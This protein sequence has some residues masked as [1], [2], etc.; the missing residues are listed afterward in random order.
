MNKYTSFFTASLACVSASCVIEAQS[1]P[2][3]YTGTL[4]LDWTIS[5]AKD[6]NACTQC[7]VRSIAIDLRDGRGNVTENDGADCGAFATTIRVSEGCYKVR[8]WLIEA[9]ATPPTSAITLPSLD[10]I[11]NTRASGARRL[12]RE[13]LFLGRLLYGVSGAIAVTDDAER[14]YD[15]TGRI[16]AAT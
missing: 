9:S 15:G 16:P 2:V 13:G 6:P 10:V 5:G 8:A 14:P 4:A 11:A 12:P 1:V 7:N 3:S